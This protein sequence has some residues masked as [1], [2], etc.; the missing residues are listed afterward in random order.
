MGIP[1]ID[2]AKILLE[3]ANHWHKL[4]FLYAVSGSSFLIVLGVLANVA[5]F[6]G[7]NFL[8]ATVTIITSLY[9]LT[10]PEHVLTTFGFGAIVS[11]LSNFNLKDSLD[12]GLSDL[13]NSIKP[14]GLLF[15][16]VTIV[17][18]TLATF[19]IANAA[20]VLPLIVTLAG[21]QLTTIVKRPGYKMFVVTILLFSGCLTLYKMYVRPTKTAL[22]AGEILKMNQENLDKQKA[23]EIE[24]L[25]EELKNGQVL[26]PEQ[27]R[28]VEEN[29]NASRG[30]SF[31][32]KAKA[33]Y[34]EKT[35]T[36]FQKEQFVLPVPASAPVK[37][38]KQSGN[39]VPL[40]DADEA[41]IRS[42]VNNVIN[43]NNSGNVE[44]VLKLYSNHVEYF[45]KGLVAKKFIEIDKYN[46]Y[47][48]WPVVNNSLNGGI[49]IQNTSEKNIWLLTYN[50]IYLTQNPVRREQSSGV[51]I[52][53]LKVSKING[54]FIILSEKQ[55]IVRR[56]K[57]SY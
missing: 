28:L 57:S 32:E 11:G 22:V 21:L 47:K 45:S 52:T 27:I 33:L 26:T 2:D 24:K 53:F 44:S 55:K 20:M 23:N 49:N 25:R 42:F 14:I 8:L 40:M 46:F 39:E 5:G 6:P 34:V 51:A 31:F 48:R 13:K 43:I 19:P 3:K 50:I 17:F 41:G 18:V 54:G 30:D 12:C 37:I 56:E 35:Q 16:F 9:F 29:V 10:K 4:G 15:L 36:G 38:Y 7:L 1:V